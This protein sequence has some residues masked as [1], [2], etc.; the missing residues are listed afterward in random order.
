MLYYNPLDAFANSIRL[1][2]E[3]RNR[4]KE[5]GIKPSLR[6]LRLE[7]MRFLATNAI[8]IAK[9]CGISTRLPV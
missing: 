9:Q 8:A 5:P 6:R 3:R 2:V 7:S 1:A 4:A